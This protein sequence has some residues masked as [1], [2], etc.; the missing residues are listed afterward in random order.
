MFKNNLIIIVMYF[1]TIEL[2]MQENYI[3]S[4]TIVNAWGDGSSYNF[5]SQRK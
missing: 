4:M 5:C 1:V 3:I 2:N